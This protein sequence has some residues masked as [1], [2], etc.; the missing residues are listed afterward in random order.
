[1]TATFSI[2]SVP[3]VRTADE[4]SL[5]RFD[6][7]A[8]SEQDRMELLVIGL[9]S[10][11]SQYQDN[12]G[13]FID[14]HEW[15]NVVSD[16][17]QNITSIN[18]GNSRWY[19]GP[20]HLTGTIDTH[21]LPPQ[22]DQFC[23]NWNHLHG[24][25]NLETLPKNLTVF[26]ITSN[27]CHGEVSLIALPA[28]L[29]VLDLSQNKFSG[30]LNLTKLPESLDVLNCAENNFS[31]SIDLENLPKAISAISFQKNKLSGTLKFDKLPESLRSIDLSENRFVGSF[32]APL[33]PASLE[34]LYVEKNQMS[35]LAVVPC[36]T[37]VE[38]SLERNNFTDVEDARGLFPSDTVYS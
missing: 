4:S 25:V 35:G 12:D 32:D 7:S 15:R 13:N 37:D 23:A 9:E 16:S 19:S 21:L 10:E 6:L 29:E 38:I 34:K 22:L 11:L 20:L 33:L 18:E 31:G 5:G 26:T 24:E 28:T 8:L 17:E 36:D 30:S 2:L 3:L 27:K 1:M 14:C